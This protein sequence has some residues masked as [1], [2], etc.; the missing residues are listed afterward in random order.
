[1]IGWGEA[2]LPRL[3]PD[4][5]RRPIGPYIKDNR[6]YIKDNRRADPCGNR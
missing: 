4:R 2:R 1:M 6:P 3:I 5:Y